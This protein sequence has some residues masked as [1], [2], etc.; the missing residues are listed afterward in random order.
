MAN[1]V[2]KG[3]IKK[4]RK[5]CPMFRG[6]GKYKAEWAEQVGKYI[7]LDN[8]CSPSFQFFVSELHRRLKTA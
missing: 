1:A 2:F 8:N 3:G 7:K 5:E 6:V 4:F